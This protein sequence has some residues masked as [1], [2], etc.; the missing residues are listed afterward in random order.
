MK[1]F[2]LWLRKRLLFVVMKHRVIVRHRKV[3]FANQFENWAEQSATAV[4]SHDNARRDA[5]ACAV[6]EAQ[7]DCCRQKQRTEHSFAAC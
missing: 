6:Q 2:A 3:D 7:Q 1:V 4:H 5:F